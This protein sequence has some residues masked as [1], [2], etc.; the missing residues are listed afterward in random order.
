MSPGPVSHN[1]TPLRCKVT[2]ARSQ[3][4]GRFEQPRGRIRPV[5][6]LPVCDLPPRCLLHHLTCQKHARA[7]FRTLLLLASEAFEHATIWASRPKPSDWC[8][9]IFYYPFSYTA[10]RFI[11]IIIIT[12]IIITN[13]KNRAITLLSTGPWQARGQS[14][15]ELLD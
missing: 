10:T 6:T 3:Q 11:T 13:E 14:T 4:G 5:C 8:C 7:G 12:I 2:D 9:C 1:S 15:A